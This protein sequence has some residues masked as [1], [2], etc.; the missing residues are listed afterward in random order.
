[1][2]YGIKALYLRGRVARDYHISGALFFHDFYMVSNE[3]L[4]LI[5]Y[6]E[7]IGTGFFAQKGHF[8]IFSKKKS[9]FQGVTMKN[10]KMG[11]NLTFCVRNVSKLGQ[12][13]V[14]T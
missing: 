4:E 2:V 14:C 8:L 3:N 5:C 7:P 10:R 6:S 12:N 9:P 1:M 11:Q 13:I